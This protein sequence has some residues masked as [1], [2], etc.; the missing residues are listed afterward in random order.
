MDYIFQINDLI[1]TGFLITTPL[2]FLGYYFLK[3]KRE[4][5]GTLVEISNTLV[6]FS[7]FLYIAS[8]FSG[9][10]SFNEFVQFR[11]IELF[12][13]AFPYWLFSWVKLIFFVLVPQTFWIKKYRKNINLSLMLIPILSYDFYE[14][15]LMRKLVNPSWHFYKV[16]DWKYFMVVLFSYSS[17]LLF[18]LFLQKTCKN[19]FS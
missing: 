15:F 6:L 8:L 17:L 16:M 4:G 14:G 11:I 3:N 5:I 1:I 18:T 12:F 7:S 2:L 9:I 10:A 19:K 13:G